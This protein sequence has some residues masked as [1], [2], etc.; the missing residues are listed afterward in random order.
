[1]CWSPPYTRELNAIVERSHQT[2]FNM[3][4]SMLLG[5]VVPMKHWT[6]AIQYAVYISIIAFPRLL[7]MDTWHPTRLSTE[8]HLVGE[9]K[10][11]GCVCYA[12]IPA[13]SREKRF[14]DKS[15]RGYFGYFLDV[16][17]P[18]GCALVYFIEL[19]L[20]GKSA[21]LIFD[22]VSELKRDVTQTLEIQE[23]RRVTGD[24]E[25]LVGMLYRD[26]NDELVYVTQSVTT[27]RGFIVAWVARVS[28][29]GKVGPSTYA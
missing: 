8:L 26:D 28:I 1:M 13:E 24:F 20:V 12:H 9:I 7:K 29:D 14:T 21:H 15:Y 16:H 17:E 5:A 19:D 6:Y 25:C 22:E 27:Q 10:T 11:W 23:K 18:T 4:H 3:G 2:I